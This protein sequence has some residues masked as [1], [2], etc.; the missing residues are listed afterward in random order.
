MESLKKLKAK[1]WKEMAK[2]RRI[3][4]DL[5]EK[6]KTHKGLWCQMMMICIVF[7]ITCRVIQSP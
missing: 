1:N 3:G 7:Y 6:A 4:R 2:G 5:A